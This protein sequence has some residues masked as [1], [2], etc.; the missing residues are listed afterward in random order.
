[1]ERKI[2]KNKHIGAYGVIIEDNKIVLIKK[3]RGGYIGKLDLPGGGIE[4]TENPIE[5][6]NRE[7]MGEAG[8]IV[9]E[10]N[11]QFNLMKEKEE[12]SAL[13]KLFLTKKERKYRKHSGLKFLKAKYMKV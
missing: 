3:A 5:A 13:S 2:V 7:L 1:M 6:L 8:V 4:H 9:E 11:L 12:Q 10:Q